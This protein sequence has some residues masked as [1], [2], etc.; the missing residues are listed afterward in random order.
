LVDTATSLIHRINVVFEQKLERDRGIFGAKLR[1]QPCLAALGFLA[2][3]MPRVSR[4]QR[5]VP[6]VWQRCLI[7]NP[8]LPRF[9]LSAILSVMDQL[10]SQ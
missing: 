6:N 9:L 7:R 5:N 2:L 8:A 10:C 4:L 3:A 1:L